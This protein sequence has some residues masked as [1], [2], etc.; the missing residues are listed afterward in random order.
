M[1]NEIEN[2]IELAVSTAKKVQVEA[3]T[4]IDNERM[5]RLELGKNIQRQ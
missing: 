1:N 3:N 5:S 4:M 2:K